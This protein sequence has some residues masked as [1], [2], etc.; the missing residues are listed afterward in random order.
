[1]DKFVGIIIHK[2]ECN[3]I[4]FQFHDVQVLTSFH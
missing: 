1:M 2:Y 3:L 4:N